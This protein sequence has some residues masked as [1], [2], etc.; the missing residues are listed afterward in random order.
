M[1]RRH[2]SLRLAPRR[3]FA[4]PDL[5]C[6]SRRSLL[7]LRRGRLAGTRL[8]GWLVGL[9]DVVLHEEHMCVIYCMKW[10]LGSCPPAGI[11]DLFELHMCMQD[12]LGEPK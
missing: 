2:L 5:R 10:D 7:H 1:R 6:R 8:A 12:P 3:S 9:A 11:W 4:P